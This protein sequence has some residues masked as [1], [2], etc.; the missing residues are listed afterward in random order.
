VTLR[1]EEVSFAYGPVRVLDHVSLEVHPGRVTALFGPNGTGKSTL[2]RCVLGLLRS[3]GEVF[4]DGETTSSW[5]AQ[6]MARHVALVPQDHRATFPHTVR[7]MVTMG[8]T[9][10]GASLLGP[11]TRD[12]AVALEQLDHLGLL[13]LADRTFSSL[14]GGQR[15]LVLIAR[16]LAQ[17]TRY[18]L[19][20]EPT[21]SLDFGNQLLIWRTIRTLA[22][23]RG[24]GILVCSHDPNHVLWFCDD[25][26]VLRRDGTAPDTGAARQVVTEATLRALY[27]EHPK[28]AMT[29]GVPIVIPATPVP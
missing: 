29:D 2:F 10:R 28:V 27:P 1:V 19:F 9:A 7:D 5:S 24:K 3:S 21:A 15:Q 20:D 12:V 26:V 14:S 13:Q 25:A 22:H 8:A 16:A 11:S 18:L 6:R 23:E 17:D 4:M